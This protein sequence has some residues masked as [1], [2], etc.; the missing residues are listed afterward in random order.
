VRAFTP[1]P[2]TTTFWNELGLKILAGH[3]TAGSAAP[4]K[5]VKTGNTVAIGTG[6]GLFAPERVQLQGRSAVSIDDFLRGYE[7]FTGAQLT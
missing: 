7:G 6:E 5:V 3:V 4:G 2:G 1:W